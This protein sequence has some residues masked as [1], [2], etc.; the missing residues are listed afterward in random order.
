MN[1]KHHTKVKFVRFFYANM[2][3]GCF[4]VILRDEKV[5]WRLTAFLGVFLFGGQIMARCKECGYRIRGKNHNKGKH[6]EEKHPKKRS[7][8]V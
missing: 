5:W 8:D 6:H 7:S 1:T 4:S 3:P 2:T